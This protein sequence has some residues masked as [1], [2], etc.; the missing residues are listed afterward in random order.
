[1]PLACECVDYVGIYCGNIVNLRLGVR[2]R[3]GLE[4]Q[5]RLEDS[6]RVFPPNLK[7]IKA[8]ITTSPLA[9]MIDGKESQTRS[10]GPLTF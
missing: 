2:K 8:S 1:M 4:T 6:S 9:K 5:P 7:I 3:K 10:H